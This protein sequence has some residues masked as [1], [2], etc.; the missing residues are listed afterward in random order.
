MANPLARVVMNGIA[1][2]SEMVEAR[3]TGTNSRTN[4]GK[5]ETQILTS[6]LNNN[7]K[8]GSNPKNKSNYG[9]STNMGNSSPSMQ[10]LD[11][12][13]S[14][15]TESSKNSVLQNEKTECP[16]NRSRQNLKSLCTLENISV[17]KT[18][19]NTTTNISINTNRN[20]VQ[21]LS[22]NELVKGEIKSAK[23]ESNSS[24]KEQTAGMTTLGNLAKSKSKNSHSE[25]RKSTNV[26]N[27]ATKG[28]Y[29]KSNVINNLAANIPTVTLE[30][31]GKKGSL[32]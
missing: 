16:I 3:S 32:F 22:L 30:S 12:L 5:R 15:K 25:D 7:N 21:T 1:Q 6:L 10:S 4:L 20:K 27:I 19:T 9:R 31:I 11:S 29:I 2:K 14:G 8:N 18:N 23:T 13:I 24:Y 26:D 17:G 28:A